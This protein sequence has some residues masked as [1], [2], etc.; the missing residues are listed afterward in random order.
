M[1]KRNDDDEKAEPHFFLIES[2]QWGILPSDVS[3]KKTREFVCRR[4]N[5]CLEHRSC[6]A[7]IGGV[8]FLVPEAHERF[9]RWPSTSV[10]PSPEVD[11]RETN[12]WDEIQRGCADSLH[13]GNHISTG[14]PSS[15]NDRRE[16]ER[17]T[18]KSRS[19]DS[20]AD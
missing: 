13:I 18:R 9:V 8:F 4:Q 19:L 3:K 2:R 12:V 7:K 6:F 17:A 1:Q 15:P 5:R 20:A 10:R 16:S 11:R 14:L